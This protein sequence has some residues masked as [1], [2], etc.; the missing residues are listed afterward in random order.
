M[1]PRMKG[2]GSAWCPELELPLSLEQ[3]KAPTSG[4][5][6]RHLPPGHT[7]GVLGSVRRPD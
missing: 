5:R 3:Q 1:G 6:H 4:A 7:A 2:G